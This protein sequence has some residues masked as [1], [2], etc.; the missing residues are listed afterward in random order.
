MPR[1]FAPLANHPVLAHGGDGFEMF[2]AR[3]GEFV[4]GWSELR[5]CWL[6]SA[7]NSQ[8]KSLSSGLNS[9]RRLDGRMRVVAD[10]LEVLE[11]EVVDVLHR[12]VQLHLRQRPGLAGQLQ[13]RLLQMIA[14]EMQVTKSVNEGARLQA[15]HLR[16]HQ[17]EQRVGRDVERHTQ[18]QIRAAL[19]Q[20]AAQLTFLHEKL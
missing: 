4:V 1:D 13:L 14:V 2:Q 9:N 5:D 20:L 7:L 19:V 10:Q 18:E 17:R 11:L 15:T 8:L 6:R 16:D 12:R 3:S